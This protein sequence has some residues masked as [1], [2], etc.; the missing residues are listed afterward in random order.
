MG[1]CSVTDVIHFR[2]SPVQLLVVVRRESLVPDVGLSAYWG[3]AGN[4][5]GQFQ[6]S[7]GR[8]QQSALETIKMVHPILL[9]VHNN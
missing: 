3:Y 2:N 7:L 6:R 9:P 5:N 4:T 8:E 1:D